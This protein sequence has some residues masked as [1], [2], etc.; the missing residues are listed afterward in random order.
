MQ[1][2]QLFENFRNF[3]RTLQEGGGKAPSLTGGTALTP[4]LVQEALEEYQRFIS[5]WNNWL[6]SKFTEP[7][8]MGSDEYLAQEREIN[9]PPLNYAGPVGSVAYT[10]QDIEQDKDVIYGDIDVLVE[11]PM[12]S[13][14]QI[15]DATQE[16]LV[17]LALQRNYK[18]QLIDYIEETQPVNIHA[19]AT[20][21]RNEFSE[22][23]KEPFMVILQLPNGAYV[24]ADSII[25]YSDIS[26]WTKARYTPMRGFKGYIHGNF[27][28]VLSDM[29]N[30][31][32]SRSGVVAKFR[33]G[34][35]VPPRMRKDVRVKTISSNPRTFFVD[36]LQV[37]AGSEA[38]SNP[39]L[40][41][42]PGL[43]PETHETELL[44]T[45]ASGAKG[46]LIALEDND[47]LDNAEE[48]VR[49]LYS[50]YKAK[51]DQ[52]AERRETKDPTANG[53]FTEMSDTATQ[54]VADILLR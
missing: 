25:T 52:E 11:I 44:R 36:I 35:I 43:D 40:D 42:N 34:E 31:S 39:L 14:V 47:A 20:L 1:M 3:A 49:T 9:L 16:R 48:K 41:A 2:Q 30:V 29:L 51:N 23:L 10:Q 8:P 6:E 7:E 12:P 18:R 33:G 19:D 26:S 24:Q 28:D 54:M 27:Y 45:L 15:E 32:L 38:R 21:S 5:Q 22:N 53:K 17:K 4:E 37:F 13:W 46:L 50:N